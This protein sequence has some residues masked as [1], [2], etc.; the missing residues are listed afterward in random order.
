MS[1]FT[2]SNNSV[3]RIFGVPLN[4]HHWFAYMENGKF[5]MGIKHHY[6]TKN[7]RMRSNVLRW[8]QFPPRERP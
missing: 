4:Q 1:S 8:R 2:L 3:R 7:E 6:V 5:Q